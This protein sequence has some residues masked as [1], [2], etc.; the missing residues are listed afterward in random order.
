MELIWAVIKLSEYLVFKPIWW[1]ASYLAT[2]FF[3]YEGDNNHD[4]LAIFFSVVIL[5]LLIFGCIEF[6]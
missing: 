3:P 5:G 4:L 1:V 2:P 6:L